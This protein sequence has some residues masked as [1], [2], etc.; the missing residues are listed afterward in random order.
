MADFHIHNKIFFFSTSEERCHLCWRNCRK[1]K[2]SWH[3]GTARYN[4]GRPSRRFVPSCIRRFVDPSR[5]PW[6]SGAS[7]TRPRRISADWSKGVAICS[8]VSTSRLKSRFPL[9]K[10]FERN[11]CTWL[12]LPNSTPLNGNRFKING[13][14][15]H[16]FCRR[17]FILLHY[18][19]VLFKRIETLQRYSFFDA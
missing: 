8:A 6:I 5:S 15:M 9:W 11:G 12:P 1:L 16:R 19:V 10:L 3:S 2:W 17:A 13:R 14:V 4:G 7:V 18:L